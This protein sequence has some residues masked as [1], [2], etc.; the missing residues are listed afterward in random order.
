MTHALLLLLNGLDQTELGAAAIEVVSGTMDLEIGVTGQ[1]IGEKASA[2]F[3]GDELT[4]KGQELSFA[5]GQER[6]GG[7]EIATAECCKHREAHRYLRSILFA[8][9]R[10][11]G[12]GPY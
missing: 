6:A 10:R 11:A 9:C 4:S 1:E 7:L 8:L 5:H 12:N 3:Q 2:D